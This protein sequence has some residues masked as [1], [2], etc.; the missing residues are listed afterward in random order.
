MSALLEAAVRLTTPIGYVAL[1][2]TYAER[3]GML[4]IGL[5]GTM[6]I[7]A[8][9][10][11]W[12]AAQTGSVALGFLAG[13]AAGTLTL[14]VISLLTLVF[15]A[16]QIVVGVGA[17]LVG[18]GLTTV[19]VNSPDSV[20]GVAPGL[21]SISIP[22][23]RDIPLVGAAL[24]EQNAPFYALVALA[25]VSA[26]VFK[27]TS[28]GLRSAAV[29]ETPA[30]AD[31]A[32]IVVSRVRFQAMLTCGL[33]TG[34]GGAALS[35]GNL[36]GFTENMTAGRGF[37]ALAAVIFGR[38]KPWAVLSAAGLF[39][40]AYAVQF[41]LSTWSWAPSIPP[42]FVFMIPY[43]LTLVALAMLRGVAQPPTALAQPYERR[44]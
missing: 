33:L 2:E 39:G 3:S 25:A 6:L 1:G 36:R 29:G 27:R 20:V 8:M 24:F 15:Q 13:A 11:A 42:S 28:W 26:F 35:I 7:G 22:L 10:A 19:V 21:S 40:I 41:Q 23:L 32:G 37:I 18:L 30:A 31:A 14:A 16:D 4:N 43:A 17:N 9:S 38:W 34:L 44:R 12:G 5:E